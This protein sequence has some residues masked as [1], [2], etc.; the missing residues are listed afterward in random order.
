MR[1][2]RR[3]D[4]TAARGTWDTLPRTLIQLR[5]CFFSLRPAA[6][7]TIFFVA[8]PH[9]SAFYLLKKKKKKVHLEN[10]PEA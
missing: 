2:S 5:F 8:F 6:R 7:G 10:S 9:A 3:N 4:R 1:S